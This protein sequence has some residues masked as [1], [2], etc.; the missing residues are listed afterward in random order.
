[1]SDNEESPAS[2]AKKQSD[3]AQPILKH[4]NTILKGKYDSYLQQVEILKKEAAD[5]RETLEKMKHMDIPNII[6]AGSGH[7]AM[8]NIDELHNHM[9]DRMN[10]A[11]HLLKGDLK[12]WTR[13]NDLPVDFDYLLG[14]A[15]IDKDKYDA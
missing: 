10:G 13:K 5:R 3:N 11:M 8:D 14:L 9:N 1:M 15:I 7:I 4:G 12:S 6:K 2:P